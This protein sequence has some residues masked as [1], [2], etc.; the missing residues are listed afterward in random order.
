MGNE[1]GPWALTPST[2]LGERRLSNHQP[3]PLMA[4]DK[5]ANARPGSRSRFP[6]AQA[7]RKTRANPGVLCTV[8]FPGN[9]CSCFTSTYD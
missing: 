6:G 9:H 5:A 1:A 2:R 8:Q 4:T 7:G 3:H